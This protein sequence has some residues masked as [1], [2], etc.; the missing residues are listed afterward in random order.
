MTGG[1]LIPVNENIPVNP[2]TQNLNLNFPPT[3]AIGGNG[4]LGQPPAAPVN[5]E[6]NNLPPGNNV[7]T[8]PP[9]SGAG[10]GATGQGHNG[11][12]HPLGH[13][14]PWAAD[15]QAM[16]ADVQASVRAL[17]DQFKAQMNDM[18]TTFS[19]MM[20]NMIAA[21][22]GPDT[23]GQAHAPQANGTP[24]VVA[25]GV[26]NTAAKYR[27][28]SEWAPIGRSALSS[29]SCSHCGQQPNRSGHSHSWGTGADGMGTT[30]HTN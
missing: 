22:A 3:S 30:Q 25:S 17:Q 10:N 6:A 5:S 2:A 8:S 29:N 28:A 16:S 15:L 9:S 20:A 23:T 24:S 1:G 19:L 14:A 13:A 18:A 11:G 27:S 4:P 12:T 21:S 7:T 26:L